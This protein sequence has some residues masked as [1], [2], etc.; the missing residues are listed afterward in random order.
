MNQLGEALMSLG[1]YLQL[2]I[3]FQVAP[4]ALARNGGHRR[5][6]V[7]GQVGEAG[8]RRKCTEPL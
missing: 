7:L 4:N 3:A 1:T 2:V 5:A 6:E 8:S